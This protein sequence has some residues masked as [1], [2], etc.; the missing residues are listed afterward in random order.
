M[1]YKKPIVYDSVKRPTYSKFKEMSGKRF[2]RL[3]VL[4][5]LGKKGKPVILEVHLRLWRDN[6]GFFKVFSEKIC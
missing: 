4:A 1:K 3:F 2:E 5:F 6:Q